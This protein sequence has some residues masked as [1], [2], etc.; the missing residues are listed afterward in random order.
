M[1]NVRIPAFVEVIG[2]VLLKVVA[3][4]IVEVFIKEGVD[5]VFNARGVYVVAELR[6]NYTSYAI[7]TL[8]PPVK[9]SNVVVAGYPS[10]IPVVPDSNGSTEI[11]TIV[12]L[13]I[14]GTS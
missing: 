14:P 2:D 11:T 10:G 4:C 3:T 9:V 13:K 1:A 7:S 5:V 12:H 8:Y 6:N